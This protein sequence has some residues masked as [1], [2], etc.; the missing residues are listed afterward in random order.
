M[1]TVATLNTDA[2]LSGNTL[3]VVDTANTITGL[4]TYDRDPSAPFAVTASSA[5]VANLDADKLDGVEAASLLR[6]DAAD[7]KTAGDLTFNDSIAVTFGTG[8]D[9]DLE[10]DGTDLILNLTVVGAADFVVNGGSIELDDNEGVTFGTGK[11]ATIQYDGTN[12]IVNPAA[13]GSGQIIFGTGVAE[14]M[15]LVFDGIAQDYYIALD[16]SADDLVIGLGSTIGTTPAISIDEN[17]VVLAHVALG[18][19]ALTT[20]GIRL[21]VNSGALTVREGDDSADGPCQALT[22]K[23]SGAAGASPDIDT[24]FSDSI[25]KAWARVANAGTPTITDDFNVGSLTDNAVGDTTVTFATAT[26]TA[27]YAAIATVEDTTSGNTDQRTAQIHT[28]ATGSVR[29]LTRSHNNTTIADNDV[30]FNI[31]VVGE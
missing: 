17:Q 22:V 7:S 31:I 27:N 24:V 3:A 28:Q 4:W 8:G 11:D 23:V 9:V 18:I 14:D 2:D 25:V 12:L 5:V 30:G 13:V 16:D 29:V 6:S 20:A 26:G 10:Y 15:A 21:E 19:G 1:A